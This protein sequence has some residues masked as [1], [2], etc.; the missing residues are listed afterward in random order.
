MKLPRIVVVFTKAL[1]SR[2]ACRVH[3]RKKKK[4]G[5]V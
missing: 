5:Y 3:V 2:H 1:D 4:K